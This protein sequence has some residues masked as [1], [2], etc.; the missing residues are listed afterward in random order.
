[1]LKITPS[2]AKACKSQDLH[3]LLHRLFNHL[4]ERDLDHIDRQCCLASIDTVRSE[5]AHPSR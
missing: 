3:C 4:A 2:F 1:M 5:L